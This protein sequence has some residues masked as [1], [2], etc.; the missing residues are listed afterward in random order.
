MFPL[1]SLFDCYCAIDD[2]F[3]TLI[4]CVIRTPNILSYYTTI[5]NDC[6][7]GLVYGLIT[8]NITKEEDRVKGIYEELKG[9]LAAIP[10]NGS[11]FDDNGFTSHANLI[12]EKIPSACK[13]LQNVNAYKIQSKYFEGRRGN[14]VDIVPTKA[15][16]NSI[17]GR[18]KGL[19]GLDTP[20]SS[21][22][23]TFIQNQSQSQSQTMIVTLELQEKIISEISKH[24]EGTKERSFL[25]KLKSL[26]PTV[27]GV[28]D[29]LSL[30][31]KIG[32]EF[33]L[34][35][36]SIHKLLGL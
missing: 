7:Y 3:P 31:L 19:Y 25:E 29:I 4:G 9:V 24:A 30:A 28:M 11:W 34:D 8:N 16:L 20:L 14:I 22:G 2:D 23:N 33:G 10:E 1:L 6:K 21:N 13:E 35:A 12:I 27:K 32:A 5:V 15:K 26:L 17:I 18:L 36:T